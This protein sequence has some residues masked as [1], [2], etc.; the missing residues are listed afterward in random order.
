MK[1]KARQGIERRELGRTGEKLSILG[2]GGVIV[3]N[4]SEKEASDWVAEAFDRGINYFDVAPLYG[5]AQERLG[6]ALKPYRN[7]CFLACKSRKRTVAEVEE[8]LHNSLRLMKTD[9]F[10]LYQLHCLEFMERDIEPV[11]RPGGILEFLLKAQKAGKFRHFGFSAHSEQAAHAA[12]D[13]WEFDSILFPFNYAMWNR[14]EFGPS[15]HQRAKEKGM[16]ILALKSM[17]RAR[18]PEEMK[19]EERPWRKCWYEPIEDRKLS[20][21]NLRFTLNLPVA[22][23]IPPGHWELF[24]TALDIVQSGGLE[25]LSIEDSETL[26]RAAGE[27]DPLFKKSA[28]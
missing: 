18:W 13:A 2:F 1:D 14:G 26:E 17:S 6:P 10:D 24:K 12:M 16:G 4:A 28:A 20:A 15:I 23:A 25:P 9:C 5:N 21:L 7:N 22:A 11:F 27:I 3:T 8:D 19:P